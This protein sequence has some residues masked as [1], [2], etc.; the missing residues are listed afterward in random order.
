MGSW[1]SSFKWDKNIKPN[2]S[3]TISESGPAPLSLNTPF[4]QSALD[5]FAPTAAAE[6]LRSRYSGIH[7]CAFATTVNGQTV[8]VFCRVLHRLNATDQEKEE[9]VRRTSLEFGAMLKR[10]TVRPR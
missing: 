10:I 2:R 4:S 5:S 8:D 3:L 7:V 9:D 1:V 6:F